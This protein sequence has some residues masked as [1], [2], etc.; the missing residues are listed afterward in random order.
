VKFEDLIGVLF[1]LFFLVGPALKG[2][3]KPQ[4]PLVEVELPETFPEADET[5]EPATARTARDPLWETPAFQ[6]TP[7]DDGIETAPVSSSATEEPPLPQDRPPETSRIDV[8]RRARGDK[9]RGRK[10]GL[11]TG[12]RAIINGMLWHEILS[13][14]ASIKYLKRRRGAKLE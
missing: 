6:P 5:T 4:E 7:P 2:L 12:R 11:R 13:E 3:F 10:A 1:L 8:S 9:K 14:P